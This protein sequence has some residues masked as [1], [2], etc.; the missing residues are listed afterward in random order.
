[1]AK[2][3][4][5]FYVTTSIAYTNAKPHIGFALEVLQADVLARHHCLKGEDVLFL[6]G[7]DENG[8]KIFRT[9]KKAGRKPQEFVDEI[10][11]QF[12]NLKNVLNLSNDDFIRTSDQKRHWPT[13]QYIWQKLKDNGD[14]YKKKYK[15]LYC[16]GCEAFLTEK[17]LVGGKCPNHQKEP[18]VVEEENYFF[19]LSR[20][21]DKLKDILES[22]KIKIVPE[23]KKE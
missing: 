23:S 1:M 5:K 21:Q 9:A 4:K 15:G 11:I 2:E 3:K 22:N 13:V 7:T 12:K 19:R 14:V 18:E 10:S 8:L 20:Y 6:T 17:D 16:V